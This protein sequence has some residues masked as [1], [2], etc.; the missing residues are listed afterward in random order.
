[1][2]LAYST[3]TRDQNQVAAKA[4][5]QNLAGREKKSHLTARER[6]DAATP[7]VDLLSSYT[8]AVST[9]RLSKNSRYDNLGI[10]KSEIDPSIANVV[11]EPPEDISDTPTDKSDL[12]VEGTVTDSAAFLSNDKGA[13]Y[14]EVTVRVSD[15]LKDTSDLNVRNGDSNSVWL[16][17]VF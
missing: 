13:V 9:D 4:T 1:L 12:I 16:G 5:E 15:V 11:R 3:R 17:L 14:S 8:A 6:D 10:V 7:V 2:H